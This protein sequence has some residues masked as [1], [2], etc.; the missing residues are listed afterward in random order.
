MRR[1]FTI[2]LILMQAVSMSAQ[3][4]DEFETFFLQ[5]KI[6]VNVAT[7]TNIAGNSP[8]V[9]MVFGLDL[10]YKPE[11]IFGMSVG[12]SYSM[13][14]DRTS[15]LYKR[16]TGVGVIERLDYVAVPVLGVVNVTPGLALK[17]GIQPAFNVLANANIYTALTSR[18]Y[19]LKALG[20]K[21]ETVDVSVPVG[22]SYT[23]PNGFTIEGRYYAGVTG[24]VEHTE[25]RHSVFQLTV[26]NKFEL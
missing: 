13:Q 1:L 24:I 5:P 7:I 6:G 3:T 15:G 8:R 14:G 12:V 4:N 11:G 2:S 26:G 19:S 16:F 10:E 22:I 25:M 21:T 18:N 9:G 20:V 23:F 17:V